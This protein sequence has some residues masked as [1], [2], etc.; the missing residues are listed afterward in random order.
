MLRKGKP[1][2]G[3]NE[4]TNPKISKFD[5]SLLL[6]R[7]VLLM[8]DTEYVTGMVRFSIY[9]KDGTLITMF[10]QT[11]MPYVGTLGT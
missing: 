9:L 10:N 8:S 11:Q 7:H 4:A 1:A 5:S 6:P 3:K 2:G